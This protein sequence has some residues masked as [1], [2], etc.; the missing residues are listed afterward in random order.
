[1]ANSNT[2]FKN[3]ETSAKVSITT[4]TYTYDKTLNIFTKESSVLYKSTLLSDKLPSGPKYNEVYDSIELAQD[5]TSKSED[6]I[7]LLKDA[8]KY[9]LSIKEKTFI[10]KYFRVKP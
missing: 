1:M 3:L 4:N 10:I 8:G 7:Y 9:T 2:F 6:I 5:K